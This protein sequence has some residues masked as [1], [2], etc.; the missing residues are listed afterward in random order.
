M[1]EQCLGPS[2]I[3]RIAGPL[4]VGLAAGVKFLG[5]GSDR[6]GKCASKAQAE[7]VVMTLQSVDAKARHE[8]LQQQ[9]QEARRR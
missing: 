2:G 3:K 9:M 7:R 8:A 5:T 1:N 4:V 6:S